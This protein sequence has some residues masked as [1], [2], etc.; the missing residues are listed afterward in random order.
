MAQNGDTITY[1]YDGDTDGNNLYLT[2]EQEDISSVTK[3]TIDYM[4]GAGG[5]ETQ[6][7]EPN[8]GNG[9]RVENVEVDIS[10]YDTVYIW[11]G[12]QLYGRYEGG[13]TNAGG[14]TEI[15]FSDTNQ[16]DSS[17]EPFVVGAGGGGSAGSE[18]T[19]F[20]GDTSY[21]GGSGGARDA[22][23]GSGTTN[24]GS[25]GQGVAPPLGGE[26][27]DSSDS[28]KQQG[29]DGSG[30]VNTSISEVTASGST[31]KGGGSSSGEDAEVQIT[32]KTI[33]PTPSNVQITDTATEDELTIDWDS[34]NDATGYYVYRAQSSGSTTSDYTQV[35]DVSSPPYTDTG[36]E[37]GE[38]YYYRVSSHN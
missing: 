31:I 24:D 19:D 38:K 25:E 33:L 9:G 14:S 23:F 4:D 11:V 30:A 5:A 29:G 17:D 26:G 37:D 28:F 8:G 13:S 20:N 27:G 10:N 32:Y 6:A 15:W 7:G 1:T 36:L 3:M 12:S 34:V 16:A 35:A 2:P 21:F 18:F 22:T